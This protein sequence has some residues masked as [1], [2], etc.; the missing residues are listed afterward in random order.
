MRWRDVD[1]ERA[2]ATVDRTKNGDI[3]V[4][5]LVPAVVE[6]SAVRW[7]GYLASHELA[8]KRLSRRPPKSSS[9]RLASSRESCIPPSSDRRMR[10]S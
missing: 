2:E 1:L 4:L 10:E 5:P 3:K 9:H 6:V 8:V 7:P